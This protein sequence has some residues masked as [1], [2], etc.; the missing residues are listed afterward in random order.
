MK[1]K[2]IIIIA[3]VVILIFIAGIFILTRK[4]EEFTSTSMF[5]SADTAIYYE[6]RAMQE[7]WGKDTIEILKGGKSTY[8]EY[9]DLKLKNSYTFETS[10]AE[11]TQIL[12]LVEK[13][14]FLSLKDEYVDPMIMDGEVEKLT[15]T[16]G[17]QTKTVMI[18]NTYREEF[19][20]VV[21]ELFKLV[22]MKTDAKVN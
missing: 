3:I 16:Y 9:E 18:V 5:D 20:R 14:N 12:D 6:D 21:T 10:Q 4:D 2:S 22:E 13:S 15:I 17:D 7:E 8:N 19:T 11:M 1:K